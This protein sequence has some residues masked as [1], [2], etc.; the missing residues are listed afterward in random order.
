[1][2]MQAR[3]HAVVDH[4]AHEASQLGV[5]A[6]LGDDLV[7]RHRVEHQVAAQ[8]LELQ[9]LVVHHGAAGIERQ[10][11]LARGLRVHG[12]EEVDLLLARDVAVTVRADRVPR[13]QSGDVGRKQV[14]ARNGHAHLEDGPQE[15][16]VCGLAARSVDRGDL[17]AEV[18]DAALR[19]DGC[20]RGQQVRGSHADRPRV[21]PGP[22]SA[23]SAAGAHPGDDS[24]SIGAR[25]VLALPLIG[26]LP[27]RHTR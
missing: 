17:N 8:L 6:D 12:D 13:R 4:V 16:Q 25:R 1:M 21:G 7:E 10:H 3:Q 22:R 11:V 15:H 18:V 27:C 19:R 24:T 9:R 23:T 26:A 14:L 5:R 2:P 20:W